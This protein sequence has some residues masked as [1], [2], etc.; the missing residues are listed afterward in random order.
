M[1]TVAITIRVPPTGELETSGGG[2]QA[3]DEQMKEEQAARDKLLATL[4]PF[5]QSLPQRPPAR[6]GNVTAFQLLGVHVDWNLS[7]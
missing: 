3:T 4:V 2:P 7:D 5:L 1:S 6:T